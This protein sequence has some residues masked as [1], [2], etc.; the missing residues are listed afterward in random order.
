MFERLAILVLGMGIGAWCTPPA[1]E[2]V[3]RLIMG[4]AALHPDR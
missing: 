3:V 4:R 2:I 1:S